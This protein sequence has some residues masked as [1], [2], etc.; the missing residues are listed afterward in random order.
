MW[1]N[2][3]G[4]VF[5]FFISSFC[6]FCKKSRLPAQTVTERWVTWRL[7]QLW[8]INSNTVWRFVPLLNSNTTLATLKK[9]DSTFRHC[10]VFI[11]NSRANGRLRLFVQRALALTTRPRRRPVH[12]RSVLMVLSGR[13]QF[14]YL[15][16]QTVHG[17]IDPGRSQGPSTHWGR[18]RPDLG[19]KKSGDESGCAPRVPRPP[20][21]YVV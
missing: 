10:D 2:G 1:L 6:I 15:W 9:D 19:K 3:C 16:H 5:F 7:C 13:D 14:S 20:A 12:Q 21:L 4:R 8:L 17:V 18:Q 11:P